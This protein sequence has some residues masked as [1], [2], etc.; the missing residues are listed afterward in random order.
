M[1]QIYQVDQVLPESQDLLSDPDPPLDQEHQLLQGHQDHHHVHVLQV[2]Q[3]ILFLPLV[4]LGLSH[5]IRN[6]A[7]TDRFEI[8]IN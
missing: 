8:Q 2:A 4:Q 6:L 3:V 7:N 5:Y 1:V